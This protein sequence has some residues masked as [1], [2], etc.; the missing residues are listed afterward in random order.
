VPV[1]Q[2]ERFLINIL[3]VLL[4]ELPVCG[5]CCVEFTAP[6]QEGVGMSA[7]QKAASE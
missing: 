3:I 5:W 6:E 2:E 7:L 1:P 4:L